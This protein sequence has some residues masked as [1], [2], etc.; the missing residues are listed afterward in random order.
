MRLVVADPSLWLL[1]TL[2]F[3]ARGGI[4]VLALP[5]WNLPEPVEL[6]TFL[7]PDL[8]AAPTPGL[9][10]LLVAVVALIS[11]VV[12]LLALVVGAVADVA[13][14]ERVA[15]ALRGWRSP[16]RG[17][18]RPRAWRLR[19]ELVGLSGLLLLPAGVALV[20]AVAR[21]ADV[22][23]AEV[24]NPSSLRDPLVLRVVA[25]ALPSLLLL[26]AA[27]VVGE[28]V[29]SV[30]SRRALARG[31]GFGMRARADSHRARRFGLVVATALAAWGVTLALLVPVVALIAGA[32]RVLEASYLSGTTLGDPRESL[33][34]V[35][36][37]VAFVALWLAALV[38]AGLASAVRSAL[39]TIRYLA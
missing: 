37:T 10:E 30:A 15:G 23:H 27:L 28:A 18:E 14:F 36:L 32:W 13:C 19:A 24:L 6:S 26:A 1:G 3:I 22:A 12:L 25:G 21:I 33:V 31:L 34:A 35:L 20:A 4:L 9:L 5:M 16:E 11:A 7:S 17:L 39:W 8:V 29:I 2:G 38:A